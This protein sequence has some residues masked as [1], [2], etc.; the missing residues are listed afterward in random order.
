M[1]QERFRQPQ[2]LILKKGLIV[3]MNSA[4]EIGRGD[5]LIDGDRIAA[6][7]RFD[8]PAIPSIDCAD[9]LILPGFIQTHVHLCQTLFRGQAD[10]LELLDW[11]HRRVWPYEAALDAQAMRASAQLG[12]AELIKGG[13]TCVLDMGSVRHYDVVFDEL[14]QSGLRAFGGKCMMDHPQ[15]VPAGR[16]ESKQH[17]LHESV[18]L[19]KVWH[20]NDNARLRY[21]IAPRFAVSCTDDLMADAAALARENGF[22]LHTHA[23]ETR[24]ELRLIEKRAGCGNIAFLHRLGFSGPDVTLAHCIWLSGSEKR[25]MQETGTAVAHCPSSNLKLASGIAPIVDYLRRGIKVGLGADGAPCN[26]NLEML[27]EM[28]LA[29]LL[30]KPRYGA[31]ALDAEKI[32]KMATRGGAQVLGIANEVGSI[33]AGKK[34]DLIGI[35]C[36]TIF[37]QPSTDPYSQLVYATSG[38][39]V[40]LSL[41]DGKL[42]MRNRELLTMDEEKIVAQAKSELRRVVQRMETC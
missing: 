29:A 2:K 31:A 22:L 10:D 41:V 33:E 25:L 4:D 18:Q 27:T 24:D 6:V 20:G 26:N 35:E 23:S 34:A 42:L 5:V 3:T 30:Q 16:L 32:V 7:G 11:L 15:T 12:I 21:A 17:S 37:S 40:V 13:T 28:R 14:A 36:E 38:R 9:L 8:E 19:A 1:N 39:D